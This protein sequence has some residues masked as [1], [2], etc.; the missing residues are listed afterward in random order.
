MSRLPA[1]RRREQLLDT[2]ARL[3]ATLGYAGATTSQIAREAGV[4][5]PIIY[6][7]F[8]SKRDLF[9]ALIER[10]GEDTIRLWEHELRSAPDPAERLKRLIRANPM[11]A[12]RSSP[13][14]GRG[15]YRVIIQAMTEVEDPQ[16]LEA[17]SRHVTKLLAFLREEVQRA[18]ESGQVSKRFSPEITAWSLI[19]MGLGYGLLSALG[20]PG[21]G[22]DKAGVHVTDLIGELMLGERYRKAAE[23]GKD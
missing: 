21:H 22:M 18:Q 1:A 2:A 10:T 9:I 17:L 6:R 14:G 23:S 13:G 19:H 8:D 16:I 20:M 12:A 3:F 11:V 7:H 15:V 5:E 4:T